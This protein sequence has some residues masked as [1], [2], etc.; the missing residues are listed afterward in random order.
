[1]NAV[2]AHCKVV[3]LGQFAS[4]KTSIINRAIYDTF[5]DDSTPTVGANYQR[6]R[7]LIR[8]RDPVD[9][10]IWDTAGQDQFQ[11]LLPN[12]V[13]GADVALLTTAINDAA[14]TP[15][16]P[17]ILV[18]NK[19]DLANTCSLTTDEIHGRFKA[20]FASVFFVS[21]LSGENINNLFTQVAL[22]AEKFSQGI[23]RP[24]AVPIPTG[25]EPQTQSCC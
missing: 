7:V 3:I 6:K 13:H 15:R 8:G 17:L 12:Y 19:I 21:A 18:V 5:A 14:C 20:Q 24:K 22:E 16:P 4:G 9:L 1:M 10:N 11:D 25:P 23:V 2:I